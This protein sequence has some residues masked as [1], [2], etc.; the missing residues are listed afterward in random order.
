VIDIDET[1][2]AEL[3]YVF[4]V[5]FILNSNYQRAAAR[6]RMRKMAELPYQVLQLY[7]FGV[8]MVEDPKDEK[9]WTFR[10]LSWPHC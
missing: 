6:S 7:G 9:A 1:L 3:G 5:E 2:A 4:Y 10:V 8:I